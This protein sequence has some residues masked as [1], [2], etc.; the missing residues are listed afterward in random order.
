L[1]GFHPAYAERISQ[2][3]AKVNSEVELEIADNTD[4]AELKE[5]A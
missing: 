2:A 3:E 4:T 5:V 1:L